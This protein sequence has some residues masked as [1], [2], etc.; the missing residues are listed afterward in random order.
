VGLCTLGTQNSAGNR[1]ENTLTAGPTGE[2][3]GEWGPVPRSARPAPPAV[4][5]SA[6][7]KGPPGTTGTTGHHRHHGGTTGH[8]LGW[9]FLNDPGR[10][11]RP[12]NTR[13]P[14][15]AMKKPGPVPRTPPTPRTTRGKMAD[16]PHRGTA[17]TREETR[18]APAGTAAPRH[19]RKRRHTA[20]YD[21]P[22]RTTAPPV[23]PAGRLLPPAPALRPNPP[24]SRG[25]P[26]P[27]G[28]L[29]DPL[30]PLPIAGSTVALEKKRIDSDSLAPQLHRV[31][32]P[33]GAGFK[34]A[35]PLA[36]SLAEMGN[37]SLKGRLPSAG[38]SALILSQTGR[39]KDATARSDTSSLRRSEIS[40]VVG[41]R[42]RSVAG[43]Q[44]QRPLLS[45]FA[46]THWRE[47]RGQCRKGGNHCIHLIF[48]ASPAERGSD[49]E[50][51]QGT[52]FS[53]NGTERRGRP[54]KI[55]S[56]H[57]KWSDL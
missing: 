15:T 38:P 16:P 5:A 50:T 8:H 54:S 35:A 43:G 37:V 27:L 29:V 46:V 21:E 28:S 45:R 44:V 32:M 13:E 18:P 14:A 26:L 53:K 39:T 4:T 1:P 40:P 22:R 20:R 2:P 41:A 23:A 36:L 57:W 19:R 9:Y 3:P 51:A 10:P 11:P 55:D 6:A 48:I 34:T 7:K 56:I 12:G 49:G 52:E 33:L 42:P 25:R 30:A 17:G 24:A 47:R 31:G